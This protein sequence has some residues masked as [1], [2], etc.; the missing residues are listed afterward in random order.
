MPRHAPDLLKGACPIVGSY[1]AKDLPLRGSAERLEQA[2]AANGIDH[3]VKEYPDA[4]HSFL[5]QY[6]G[7]TGTLAKVTG[8]GFR[9][10]AAD[11]AWRRID[12]FF[13]R[14]LRAA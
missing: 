11:D 13:E 3:D 1:G 6:D 12:A 5:T 8:I 7:V 10:P 9:A 14:H 4:S 2:L